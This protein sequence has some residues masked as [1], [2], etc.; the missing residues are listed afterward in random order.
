MIQAENEFL[1]SKLNYENV[2]GNIKDPQLLD[3]TSIIEVPLPEEL[4][5]AIEI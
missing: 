5:K 4:N 2:I 3:K 1:T